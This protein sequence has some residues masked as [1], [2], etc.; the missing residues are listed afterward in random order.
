M[1]NCASTLNRV[2]ELGGDPPPTPPPPPA[3]NRAAGSLLLSA[4]DYRANVAAISVGIFHLSLPLELVFKLNNYY[5]IA[6]LCKNIISSSCLEEINGYEI[7]IKNKRCLIYY[8]DIF[9]TYCLLVNGLYVL[10]LGD[11]Y[12]CNINTKRIQLNDLN[13][14]FI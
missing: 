2:E 3:A 12:I 10:D 6:A 4:V 5:C 1:L 8:N 13:R 14:T 9:Y 7:I 11:K